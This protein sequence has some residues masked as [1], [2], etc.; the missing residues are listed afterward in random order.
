MNRLNGDPPRIYHGPDNIGGQPRYLADWQRNN[1]GAVSDFIVFNDNPYVSNS[2]EDLKLKQLSKIAAFIKRFRFFFQ[3][4]SKYDIFHFYYAKSLLPYSID[5][6][7]LKLLGKKIV[8][9]Y[10]GSDIRLTRIEKKENPFFSLFEE[11]KKKGIPDFIKVIR[12]KWQS[13]WCDRCVANRSLYEHAK[14]GY[15]EKKIIEKIWVTN[16]IDLNQFGIPLFEQPKQKTV[17]VHAPTNI[18]YKGTIYIK[19]IIEQLK[20]EGYEFEFILAQNRPQEEIHEL[21]KRQADIIIDQVLLGDFGSVSC[22][23]MCYGKVVCAY[24][25]EDIIKRYPD[26]PIINVNINNLKDKLI[27]LIENTDDRIE[28]GKRSWEFGNKYCDRNKI[29]EELWNIYLEM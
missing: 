20:D 21:F 25:Q 27:W 6:P 28:I 10:V 4:L 17:I 13:I 3:A 12:V 5:L 19:R 22:E 2:H 9:N 23:A 29:S 26:L 7:I 14:I 8:M 18:H 15:P 1:K 24:L 16:S 11:H